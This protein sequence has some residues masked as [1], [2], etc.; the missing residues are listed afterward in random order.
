MK[1]TLNS[2]HTQVNELADKRFWGQLQGRHIGLCAVGLMRCFPH[3][4]NKEQIEISFF[5]RNPKKA[6]FKK[7]KIHSV[8]NDITFQG[9]QM[10]MVLGY[11]TYCALRDMG[12]VGINLWVRVS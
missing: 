3:V 5:K 12:L 10:T 9:K 8:G 6:G 2:G 1:I 7:L 4:H 11:A